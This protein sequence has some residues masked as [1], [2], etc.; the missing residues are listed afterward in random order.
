MISTLPNYINQASFDAYVTYLAIKRHFTTKSYDYY[1]Y[2]G[3][4]KANM[5]TFA[6]RNDA[7][8]FGKLAKKPDYVN[9][10]LSNV[11]EE[12]KIW[13]RDIVG[14]EGEQRYN[15]W[16]K[17]IDSL[18]YTFKNELGLLKDD[19][20]SNF[21]VS[22][23]QHPHLITLF[24]QKRISLETFTILAYAA[25]IFSYWEQNVVDKFIA[26]DIIDLSKKYKPFLTYDGQ[27]FNALVKDRFL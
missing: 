3:K 7:F 4:V 16:K 15:A 6:T 1:K 5:D 14:D 12:P 19:Y 11:I 9:L 23:G 2:N 20:K 22:D 18:G 13:V 10:I 21:I 27:R 17:K 26:Y 25:N 8:F 24:L